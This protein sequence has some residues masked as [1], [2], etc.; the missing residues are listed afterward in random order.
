MKSVEDLSYELKDITDKIKELEEL[1]IE[2]EILQE[3]KASECCPDVCKSIKTL[4]NKLEKD[5]V[6]INVD[7]NRNLNIMYR[8]SR[9]LG[10]GTKEEQERLQKQVVRKSERLKLLVN[11]RISELNKLKLTLKENRICLCK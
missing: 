4:I 8:A 11:E 10:T 3:K 1:K 7:K 6:G 2:A 9:I 5:L